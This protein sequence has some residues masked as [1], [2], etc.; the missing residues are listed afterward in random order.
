MK[1]NCSL[2]RCLAWLLHVCHWDSVEG[3]LWSLYMVHCENNH[4]LGGGGGGGDR[5]NSNLKTLFDK[6]CS[7]ALVKKPV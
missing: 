4:M 2:A 1:A 7:L 5:E 3:L 6:D